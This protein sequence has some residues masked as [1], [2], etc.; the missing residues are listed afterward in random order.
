M[1]VKMEWDDYWE[2]LLIEN[3]LKNKVNEINEIDIEKC[4]ECKL[5]EIC[6]KIFDDYESYRIELEEVRQKILRIVEKLPEVHLQ[7]SRIKKVDS[8]LCKIIEKKY[9][10]MLDRTN[11][12]SILSNENYKDIITDLI[13]IRLIISYRGKWKELHNGIIEIFPYKSDIEVYEK[14][15]FVPHSVEGDGFLAEIP[16]AYYA[17]GDDLSIYDDVLVNKKLKDNGYRSVHYIVSFMGVY[18]EIQ[19][20]TI[21]DE[22][23]NDCDHNFVYKK[24]SCMSFSALK[25]LSGVLSLLTNTSNDLG[26]IMQQIYELELLNEFNGKYYIKNDRE[27]KLNKISDNIET[28]HNLLR[29]FESNIMK[30][31][32]VNFGK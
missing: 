4:G 3:K 29:D 2:N 26:E 7:T 22:A 16:K 10:H 28:V 18:I 8:L 5:E 23:W 20:R 21:Y 6:H 13:G 12:Y 9:A 31:G 15:E 1:G 11:L 25:E 17:Y 27:L 19:A 14:F 32:G 24:E 30:T